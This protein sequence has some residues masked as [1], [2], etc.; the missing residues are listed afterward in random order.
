VHPL[1]ADGATK[2]S[3]QLDEWLREKKASRWKLIEGCASYAEVLILI[4]MRWD[5]QTAAACWR[6]PQ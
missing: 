2:F 1:G 5:P 3:T 6:V 4:T